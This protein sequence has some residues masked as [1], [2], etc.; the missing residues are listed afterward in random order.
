[1]IIRPHGETNV[2]LACQN[3]CV[4]CNHFIPVQNAWF[5][6]P[7]DFQ[8]DLEVASKI[9]HFER[10]NLVGG[11]PM[12]HPR[13]MELLHILKG[14]GIADTIEITSNGQAIEK[15]PDEFFQI[16]D[17]LIITP[18]KLTDRQV[19]YTKDKCA[20]FDLALQWHPVIFTEV[21]YSRKANEAD[22]HRR[23]KN[24]W[25]NVNRHVI[26]GGYFYRCCTAPFIPEI[27]L[28]LNKEHDGIALEGLTEQRLAE[29]LAQD[30][31]PAACYVCASNCGQRLEWRE[32]SRKDWF[33]ESIKNWVDITPDF[34]NV[35]GYYTKKRQ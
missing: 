15:M 22:A 35:L 9:V 26:D 29:Y 31:T 28:G 21:A 2:T 13:L 30:E 24:C 23:Y 33:K 4:A 18:Y 1:M 5:V 3:K 7:K 25:Y 17:E 32:V 8:G 34:S 20:E 12:L 6:E 10:Y 16:L 27:M 14:S 19:Q 11:E